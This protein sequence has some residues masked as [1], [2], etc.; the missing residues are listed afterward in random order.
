MWAQ[1]SQGSSTRQQWGAQCTQPCV[2]NGSHT[3]FS[4]VAWACSAPRT[5]RL[6]LKYVENSTKLFSLCGLTAYQLL[7][8]SCSGSP[9][10]FLIIQGRYLNLSKQ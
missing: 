5:S 3:E 4:C 9:S 6:F 10:L 8:G 1:T 2:T 7:I